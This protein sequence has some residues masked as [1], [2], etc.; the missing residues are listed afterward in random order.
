ME[1]ILLNSVLIVGGVYFGF[2]N[3]RLLRD[4][5][6]LRDYMQNSPKA[7]A[8]VSKYGFERATQMAREKTIPLGIAM[9]AAMVGLGVWNLSRI[10][11]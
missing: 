5:G 9:A 6:A 7:A 3:I 4:E 11:L 1:A 10:Y 2:R 8:W